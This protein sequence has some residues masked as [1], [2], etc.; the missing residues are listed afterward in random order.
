L[1][2]LHQQSLLDSA[3]CLF[4][5]KTSALSLKTGCNSVVSLKEHTQRVPSKLN[6]LPPLDSVQSSPCATACCN[7]AVQV[8]CGNYPSLCHFSR[9]LA[10]T[11]N[12][13]ERKKPTISGEFHFNLIGIPHLRPNLYIGEELKILQTHFCPKTKLK[14]SIQSMAKDFS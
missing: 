8:N 6:L 13:K 3:A 9:K 12:K 10:S 11:T 7:T 5:M 4:W 1:A 2:Y 14:T